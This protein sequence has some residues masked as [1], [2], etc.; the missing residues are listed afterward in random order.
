MYD[1]S[2]YLKVMLLIL[3][4]MITSPYFYFAQGLKMKEKKEKKNVHTIIWI[5]YK[6]KRKYWVL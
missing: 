1:A 3:K 5:Y 6:G 4:V 2:L